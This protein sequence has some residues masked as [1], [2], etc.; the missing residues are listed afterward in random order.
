M[1]STPTDLRKE[2]EARGYKPE[3]SLTFHHCGELVAF[4]TIAEELEAGMVFRTTTARL[5]WIRHF[6]KFQFT[7]RQWEKGVT[8]TF[9]VAGL[10][11]IVELA[12]QNWVAPSAAG[13]LR[14][15]PSVA[16]ADLRSIA[17]RDFGSLMVALKQEEWK[18]ALVLAGCVVEAVLAD[19]LDRQAPATREGAATQVSTAGRVKNPRGWPAKFDPTDPSRWT[20]HQMIEICGPPPGIGLLGE[21]T[22][23]AAHAV[24]DFR[25]H[26]HPREEAK[27]FASDPIGASDARMAH[28]L[29]EAVLED[30]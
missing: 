2:L 6:R 21:R 7:M 25:N 13:V 16:N 3:A 14:A 12:E 19:A 20:F 10:S 29:V 28:A 4:L 24:R 27:T 18:S 22:V 23:T 30:L 5:D 15:M 8:G 11:T 1:R 9:G 26:V 17:E